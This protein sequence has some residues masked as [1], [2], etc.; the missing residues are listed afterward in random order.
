VSGTR[1]AGKDTRLPRAVAMTAPCLA[2]RVPLA[3]PPIAA[4]PTVGGGVG[5]GGAGRAHAPRRGIAAPATTPAPTRSGG[6]WRTPPPAASPTCCLSPPTAPPAYCVPQRPSPRPHSAAVSQPCSARAREGTC[7][8]GQGEGKDAAQDRGRLA[9]SPPAG[10][11]C[12]ALCG[13]CTWLRAVRPLYATYIPRA[14]SGEPCLVALFYRSAATAMATRSV[15]ER[16]SMDSGTGSHA[17][18]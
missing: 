8:R 4:A 6:S 3:P 10:S 18:P 2:V 17:T 9:P 5:V 13:R 1:W 7:R 16:G 14:V 15:G 11:G 12:P